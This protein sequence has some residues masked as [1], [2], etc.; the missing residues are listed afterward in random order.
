MKAVLVFCE[1]RHDVVFVLRSLGAHAG[2]TWLGSTVAKLPTPFGAGG[3][4]NRGLVASRLE[5]RSVG[6]HSLQ[7][8]SHP[9]PPSFE[10]FLKSEVT[11][12]LFVV[13]LCV[14]QDRRSSVNDLLSD[15]DL[16]MG[17]G[18]PGTYDVTE[19]A[20]A[21][22]Y[23]ADDEGVQATLQAF[24]DRFTACFGDLSMLSNGA[25]LD[26][27]SVPVGCYVFHKDGADTGT[28]EDH[29]VPL[30]QSVWPARF[31]GAESY[32]NAHAQQADKVSRKNAERQKAIA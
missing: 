13:T 5:R 12:T 14:G 21:F 6:D 26:T 8:A 20:A 3:A 28:L 23:D 31:T 9:F 16:V 11:D 17:A 27:T 30:V 1:G 22:M 2:C 18:S 7:N 29:L 10:A 24:R 15:V 32:I 25:W 4:A 19:Y